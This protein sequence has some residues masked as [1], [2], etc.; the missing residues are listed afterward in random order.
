[1]PPRKQRKAQ[2]DF[3]QNPCYA[4]A[5]QFVE[6]PSDLIAALASNRRLMGLD[7]G[8]MRRHW[9]TS[10]KPKISAGW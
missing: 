8:Q 4:I 6:T 3:R 2:Y 1:V 9:P 5:M 7:L 10:S